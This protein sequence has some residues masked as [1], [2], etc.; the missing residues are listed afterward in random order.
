MSASVQVINR[1]LAQELYEETYKNPQS[2]Y[3]GK[4][5]GIANGQVV[6]SADNWNQLARRLLQVEPDPTNTFCIDMGYDYS[7]VQDVSI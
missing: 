4:L 7:Q 5:V 3:A 2:V 1:K 6:A